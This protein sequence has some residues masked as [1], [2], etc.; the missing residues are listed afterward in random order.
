[1]GFFVVHPNDTRLGD[2]MTLQ[3]KNTIT[4]FDLETG[5]LSA[6]KHPIIQ[7]AAIQVNNDF[8]KWR[9]FERKLQFDVSKA[10]PQALNVNSYER[11][12]WAA[13]AVT[14]KQAAEDFKKFIS[15]GADIEKVGKSGRPYKVARLA[16]HNA[17]F[18]RDFLFP[19]YRKLGVFLPADWHV[20][21][22]VQLALVYNTIYGVNTPSLKLGDLCEYHGI[23][24]E[25][26]HDALGDVKATALLAKHLLTKLGEAAPAA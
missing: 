14:P 7:I 16:A 19:W 4:F 23:P 11:D 1:M 6:S 13:Q 18:D 9:S 26:A 5:G 24:L 10:E 15:N 17:P 3:L 8:T 12:V 25:D 20:I 2:R 21:D 22:T